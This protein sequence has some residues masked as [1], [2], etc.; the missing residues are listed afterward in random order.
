MNVKTLNW[1]PDILKEF[2]IPEAML[3]K[4]WGTLA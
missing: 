4:V 3:P 1:D 2:E